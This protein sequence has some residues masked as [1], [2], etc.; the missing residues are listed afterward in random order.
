M[1]AF[2]RIEKLRMELDP[3]VADFSRQ[4]GNSVNTF[5][6]AARFCRDRMGIDMVPPMGV[7]VFSVRANGWFHLKPLV[8]TLDDPAYEAPTTDEPWEC[9][10][11]YYVHQG[12]RERPLYRCRKCC[13]HR[14]AI[15]SEMAKANARALPTAE[16]W[17]K[18]WP[19]WTINRIQPNAEREVYR[20]FI[21]WT[22]QA[23][24]SVP[25]LMRE[26]K[27]EHLALPLGLP[28]VLVCS[29]MHSEAEG[30]LVMFAIRRRGVTQSQP[31]HTQHQR[32]RQPVT[33]AMGRPSYD[34]ASAGY[35]I[36]QVRRGR[37]VQER[38]H[39]GYYAP[40]HASPPGRHGYYNQQPYG[41]RGTPNPH[42]HGPRGYSQVR[43]TPQSARID[44]RDRPRGPS[45]HPTDTSY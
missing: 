29:Q 17:R 27:N 23:C 41:Q 34:Q 24:A 5:C 14:V 45:W 22:G 16:Q 43:R 18:R 11:C 25:T 40:P 31:L 3:R 35:G 2:G 15:Q 21:D 33:H 8:Y 26:L 1:A 20:S 32:A 7:K 9:R 19:D 36:D 44:S 13:T 6:A 37:P 4:C 42:T 38:Q 28:G 10:H 39:G 30:H 12:V